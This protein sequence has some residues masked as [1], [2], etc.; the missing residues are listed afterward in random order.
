MDYENQLILDSN[1][2]KIRKKKNKKKKKLITYNKNKGAASKSKFLGY[3]MIKNNK[4]L[5]RFVSIMSLIYLGIICFI[6]IKKKE[7]TNKFQSN[8]SSNNLLLLNKTNIL[9]NKIDNMSTKLNEYNLTNIQINNKDY[10]NKEFESQNKSEEYIINNQNISEVEL[11]EISFEKFD[12]NILQQIKNQQMEFCNNEKKYIKIEFE[13]QIKLVKASLLDKEFDMYV[14]NK[15]DI[16]SIAISR[17]RTWEDIETKKLINALN[18]YS[19]LKNITNDSIYI[20]DIGS[21]VGWYTL[22]LGKLGYKI[23]A[24]EPS[25]VNMYILRKSFCLNQDL[26]ITLIKKGL[27]TEDKKCDFYISRGN[28][29][30][31]W[32]F[33]DKNSSEIP[34]HLIKGGKTYLTKL[35]NY[36]EFLSTKNLALIKIDVEGSEG[37][38]IESGIELFSKYHIPFIF[39]EFTPDS[40]AKHGTEPIKL[41]EIFENNGYK[42]AKNNFLDTYYYSKT[43]IL[44]KAKRGLINLFIVYSNITKT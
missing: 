40:L 41:L 14:Y 33:C 2:K 8:Q 25:D 17:K 23:L 10:P 27:D 44:E 16:V 24:F 31:G 4:K 19:S 42:F 34:R 11:P 5:Y 1:S 30:D 21:N 13:K 36:I 18:Y 12:E 20:L 6:F 22:F 39:L 32:V 28:I 37:K 3:K 35:S 15:S 26:N 9:E 29:G 7:I 43:E 38:A